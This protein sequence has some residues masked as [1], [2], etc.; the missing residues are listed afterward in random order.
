MKLRQGN[1]SYLLD[2]GPCVQLCRNL[3]MQWITTRKL[4]IPV[5]HIKCAL[6]NYDTVV[7]TQW[8]CNYE[9]DH[10]C[11]THQ[12]WVHMYNCRNLLMQWNYDKETMEHGGFLCKTD[13]T[14]WAH[15]MWVHMY[16]CRNLLMQ[17]N[18]DKETDHTCWTW[19]HVYNCVI[20]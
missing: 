11:W 1:W 17:W 19:V 18:Y 12:I 10:T 13:H 5:R 14:Y 15:Q 8:N 9:T 7:W 2:V 6:V 3:V 16:N 4:I 20:I